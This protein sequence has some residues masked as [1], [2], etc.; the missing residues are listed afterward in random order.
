M[1]FLART[2]CSRNKAA[3]LA[4]PSEACA[5]LRNL[6]SFSK[7]KDNRRL[8]S[9]RVESSFAGFA[10]DDE[11]EAWMRVNDML[12]IRPEILLLL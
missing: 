5:V 7:S 11:K 8:K 9:L 12:S 1:S 10:G 6:L 2:T 4:A 3:F